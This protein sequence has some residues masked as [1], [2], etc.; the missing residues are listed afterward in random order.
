[1]ISPTLYQHP[2]VLAAL[3]DAKNPVVVAYYQ[4]LLPPEPLAALEKRAQAWANGQTIGTQNPQQVA[5][6]SQWCGQ[7]LAVTTHPT[8]EAGMMLAEIAIAYPAK[9]V[10]ADWGTFLT[11]V[12]GKISMGGAIRLLDVDVSPGLEALFPG[13]A[14]G[15][16]GIRQKTGVRNV[17]TPLLMGILKPCMGVEPPQLAESLYEMACARLNLVKDDEVLSDVS[18]EAALNRF[19]L[20]KMALNKAF[21]ETGNR[22]LYAFVLT[23]PAHQWLDRAKRLAEAGCEAFLIN[24]LVYGLPLLAD[25]RA[26][27]PKNVAL[28]AHP[29]LGG[30]FYGS[31]YH[32]V[33]PQALFGTLPRLA[34]ADAVLF[35]SPYGSVCLEKP[36]ALN[37]HQRLQTPLNDVLPAFS[38]PS[39]GIQAAMVPQILADFGPQVI[40]N[41][42][43]GLHDVPGGVKLGAQAFLNHWPPVSPLF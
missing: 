34:G 16:T 27:L 9:A 19:N 38:V 33:S 31:P 7:S 17:E 36:H 25:L 30:A 11:V 8:T 23:G 4:L 43:T 40:I 21:E 14:L 41:A 5:A 42:G 2:Q 39:A 28:V 32:G 13:P 18:T 22:P 20:A 35:P 10:Q 37:I 3:S 29:A 24:Y 12:F 6:L 1:M 15:M 26:A